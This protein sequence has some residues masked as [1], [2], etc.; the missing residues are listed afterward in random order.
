MILFH[1]DKINRFH[2]RTEY[3]SSN[4]N[5]IRWLYRVRATSRFV[6]AMPC[7]VHKRF[8]HM[9]HYFTYQRTK[10]SNCISDLLPACKKKKNHRKHRQPPARKNI[11]STPRPQHQP[12]YSKRHSLARISFCNRTTTDRPSRTTSMEPTPQIREQYMRCPS[13]AT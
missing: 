6:N 11:C 7:P 13:T 3:V 2:R 9:N 4:L 5:R 1:N 12:H 8:L 10:T